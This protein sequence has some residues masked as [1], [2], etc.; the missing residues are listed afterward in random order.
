MHVIAAKAVCFGDALK[1]QFKEYQAQVIR[2]AKAL[3][4]ALISMGY[5]L[6]SGGTDNH[7]MLVDL[8]KSHPDLTGKEAQNALE[9]ANITTNRNT[10]PGETRS[11]FQT[12]GVRLGSPAVT[13]RGFT[14][15]DMA[16]AAR[17]INIVLNNP[18][19]DAKIAQAKE[20]AL[21]LTA[22]HPLP[23]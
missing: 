6:T 15:E 22:A 14:V 3:A 19:D 16:E 20:I 2:N 18:K 12:S 21:T 7:L 17:A 11:P 13:T 8:R 23:Y 5:Y 9:K 4:D 1:P 10:V